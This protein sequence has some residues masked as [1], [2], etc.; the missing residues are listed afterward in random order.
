MR[1]FTKL[2]ELNT[3]YPLDVEL[4]ISRNRN[5]IKIECL[6]IEKPEL[7]LYPVYTNYGIKLER[8]IFPI[9]GK[10]INNRYI[11]YFNYVLKLLDKKKNMECFGDYFLGTILDYYIL[12]DDINYY[13]NDITNDLNFLKSD[14]YLL[15]DFLIVILQLPLKLKNYISNVKKVPKSLKKLFEIRNEIMFNGQ[16]FD[17]LKDLINL[18]P[19]NM[20]LKYINSIKSE[21]GV[22][23]FYK[24]DIDLNICILNNNFYNLI[25][26][27]LDEILND[28]INNL[29]NLIVNFYEGKMSEFQIILFIISNN[30]DLNSDNK[31][32]KDILLNCQLILDV[33]DFIDLGKVNISDLDSL[34]LFLENYPKFKKLLYEKNIPNIQFPLNYNKKE[35]NSSIIKLLYLNPEF[36]EIQKYFKP[37]LKFQMEA[38]FNKKLNLSNDKIY[39]DYTIRLYYKTYLEKD[40]LKKFNK[41]NFFRNIFYNIKWCDI[42]NNFNLI[43]MIHKN[44]HILLYYGKLN[45]VLFENT[46]FKNLLDILKNKF[47][48]IPFLESQ[49]RIYDFLLFNYNDLHEILDNFK[50]L[51]KYQLRDLSKIIFLTTLFKDKIYNNKSYIDFIYLCSKNNFLYLNNKFNLKIKNYLYINDI[52]YGKIMRDII[53]YIKKPSKK[54]SYYEKNKKL[55]I[56]YLKY[57]KKYTKYKSKYFYEKN[58]NKNIDLDIIRSTESDTWKL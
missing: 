18:R 8:I 48:V 44:S 42:I 53:S 27:Y 45:N 58:K 32:L 24:S 43:N 7:L 57:K 2:L 19:N 47:K 5:N 41:Y 14:K 10:I 29:N 15:D 1:L 12:G 31:Y 50:N 39:R 52:N 51:S 23:N 54:E 26:K 4:N 30:L 25:S 37:R 13:I 49:A 6:N 9:N 33:K 3:F 16:Y 56:L 17:N 36:T 21:V 35:L 20:E 34:K 55:K 40:N 22:N 46:I 28:K 38:I 11:F